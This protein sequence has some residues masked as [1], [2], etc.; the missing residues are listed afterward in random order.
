MADNNLFV[1][2][3][4]AFDEAENNQGVFWAV[5]FNGIVEDY[6]ISE[7]E[8]IRY[9]NGRLYAVVYGYAYPFERCFGREIEADYF[10]KHENHKSTG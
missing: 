10:R 9:R 3:K 8:A 5:D 6:L 1:D 2:I 7:I 4:T